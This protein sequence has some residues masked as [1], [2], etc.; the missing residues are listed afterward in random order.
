MHL[1]EL[2]ESDCHSNFVVIT[3]IISV[4]TQPVRILKETSS[5]DRR[6]CAFRV[7]LKE[8]PRPSGLH[9]SWPPGLQAAMPSGRRAF[10]LSRA[11]GLSFG[12]FPAFTGIY[13]LY[14]SATVFVWSTIHH[15]VYFLAFF[16]AP[17]SRARTSP[18]VIA[19]NG[20]ETDVFVLQLVLLVYIV[21]FLDV[22]STKTGS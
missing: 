13:L 18:S 5:A 20:K 6:L 11:A 21:S 19:K 14:W 1:R 22:S 2:S 9:A 4:F 8:S 7:L 10:G 3:I 15:Y 17:V 12:K 16:I